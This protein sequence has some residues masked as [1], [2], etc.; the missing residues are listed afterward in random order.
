MLTG[1]PQWLA[2][3]PEPVFVVLH[4][5]P[6]ETQSSVAVLMLPAFGW[7]DECSYR[8]R[9]DWA[10]AL[11]EQGITTAR[12]DFPGT[13]NSV[14][15]ALAPGRADSWVNATIATADWL[16]AQSQCA[17]LAAIGI[18][19][20]GLVACEA[21][22]REAPI[23]DLLLWG[24]RASGRAHVREL[25]AYAAMAV[26]GDR[27][28]DADRADGAL[29]IGGHV[30]SAE[31]AARLSQIDIA[32][33]PLPDAERR[34]VMLVGRD[35]HGID[36][37]LRAHMSDSGAEVTL[38]ESDEYQAMMSPP[39]LNSKPTKVIDASLR[40]LLAAPPV[41]AG[42]SRPATQ[43]RTRT[44][45]AVSF[46]QDGVAIRERLCVADTTAG[47]LVGVI[48]EPAVAGR[49]PYCLVTVNSGAL[50]HT[51]PNRLFVE[52]ARAAAARGIPAARFDLPGLGDSDGTAVRS[53]ERTA[54]D[55]PESL[56]VIQQIHE[57]LQGI[58]V[59]ERFV[60]G[61]F[62]LGGYLTVR[63]ALA[64]TSLLGAISI[65][66]TGFSWT[67]KQ[68]QRAIRDFTA[69]AGPDALQRAPAVSPARGPLQAA[70]AAGGR[71]RR[72]VDARARS[73]LARSDLLWRLEHRREIRDLQRGLEQLRR[74]RTHL[75]LLLSENEPL[76]RMLG[77]PRL[78]AK[79]GGCPALTV[80]R[81]PDGDHLLRPLW[82]QELVLNR[83][84][85]ALP[86]FGASSADVETETPVDA[87][88]QRPG[89][90]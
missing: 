87:L 28:P 60:A 75:L 59:A 27:T 18:G 56:A 61:G 64:G 39:D 10:T 36:G 13:E 14:G 89:K 86:E 30:M 42:A 35:A 54:D 73:L 65:N 50:R 63:A 20:G 49:A 53:F 33:Q 69:M 78:R 90:V 71:L 45:E 88:G 31:T 44:L 5:A 26:P 23:D 72:L 22:L 47:R 43:A 51:G 37:R 12:L 79:L 74:S 52:I 38:L 32:A 85:A 55:D 76:L 11:A 62:S 9:R 83:V 6:A 58:G 67:V 82:I 70:A 2:L 68:R 15:S 21:A 46:E 41:P 40:W 16:R 48:S 25:R 8:R 66:P 17:R 34:R 19:I 57:H 3:E 24:V 77:Q 81:L 7:D 4:T 80:E 29:G 1:E 84:T